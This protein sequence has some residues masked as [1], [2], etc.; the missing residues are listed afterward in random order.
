[1]GLATGVALGAAVGVYFD[2]T[3]RGLSLGLAAGLTAALATEYGTGK[4]HVFWPIIG[5]FAAAWMLVVSM[6]ERA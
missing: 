5:A 4:R 6:I 2:D 1:M 3:T